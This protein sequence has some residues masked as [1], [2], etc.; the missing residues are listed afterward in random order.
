MEMKSGVALLFFSAILIKLNLERKW[1]I[2]CTSLRQLLT[3]CLTGWRCAP[4]SMRRSGT[5]FDLEVKK[6]DSIKE[7]QLKWKISNPD[8]VD[9]ANRKKTGHEVDF[10]A[11]KCG[12]TKITC[13]YT[14]SK[15]EKKIGCVYGKCS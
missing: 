15:G 2:S 8:I 13:S 11:K 10:Y 7:N 14:N 9:F 12:T 4:G 5:I 1:M 3:R 6:G